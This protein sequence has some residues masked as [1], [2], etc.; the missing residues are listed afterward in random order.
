MRLVTGTLKYQLAQY[1]EYLVFAQFDNDIDEITR[2][3]LNKGA[4]L[5]EILKQKP[6]KPMK[7]YQQVL[8]I[9]AGAHNFIAPFI[10][11]FKKDLTAICTLY[12]VNLLKFTTGTPEREE[13]FY[14]F[15]EL[16]SLADKTDFDFAS[17]PLLFIL[18]S[19]E[20]SFYKAISPN[21]ANNYIRMNID[22]SFDLPE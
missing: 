21:I 10:A 3:I 9:L 19:F 16:L 2:G 6:N 15:Y 8:I 12:E 18:R 14:P 1:R 17:N 7:L 5:T 20:P 22:G 4:L 13:Y 11:D